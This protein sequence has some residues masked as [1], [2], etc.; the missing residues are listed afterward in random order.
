MRSGGPIYING[1][2]GALT[3]S[4]DTYYEA[5]GQRGDDLADDQSGWFCLMWSLHPRPAWGQWRVCGE[6][7]LR[8]HAKRLCSKT[9]KGTIFKPSALFRPT[10]PSDNTSP[11]DSGLRGPEEAAY[12]DGVIQRET[13]VP[14]LAL[15]YCLHSCIPGVRHCLATSRQRGFVFRMLQSPLP[16]LLRLTDRVASTMGCVA[17]WGICS[18]TDLKKVSSERA[19]RSRFACAMGKPG[20]ASSESRV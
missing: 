12:C 18:A 10:A 4:G 14:A 13:G 17:C 1:K 3:K 16:K 6:A 19:W 15:A 5:Q 11:L 7:G 2:E 8:C 20:W 9:K